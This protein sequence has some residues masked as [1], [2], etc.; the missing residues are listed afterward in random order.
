[1]KWW[2]AFGLALVA[3]SLAGNAGLAQDGSIAGVAA[4]QAQKRQHEVKAAQTMF[5]AG[6]QAFA[7]QS[8]GEAMDNFK[9]AF[10]AIP[11]V[12]AVADQR[13]VFFK[14]YQTASLEFAK[15]LIEDA[16]WVEAENTLSEVM[17]TAQRHTVPTTLIDPQVR[18]VLGDLKSKDDRYNMANSPR[19][20][21][22]I[23]VVES[24]LVLAKGYL[25]L[26]DFDRAERTYNE[27]LIVDP[28]STASRR[29]LEDVARHRM[30]YYDAAYDHTRSKML[31][32]VT[33]AWESPIPLVDL[34]MSVG[35]VD[36]ADVAYGGSALIDQKLKDIIIPRIEF[37]G[38]RLTDV[39]DYLAQKSQE[40]D[41][42]EP[43][44]T[45]RGVNLVIDSTG[46]LGGE[47]L[48]QRALTV[49]LTN[50]PLSDALKYVSQL[51]GM[52]YRVDQFAVFIVP[53][54]VEFDAGYITRR[55]SVPPGF[56]SS[57]EQG[58]GAA[59]GFSD[60]FA[61]PVAESGIRV[62]R[63][64]AKE[65]LEKSGVVFSPG[66]SASYAAATSTLIVT[67]TIDQLSTVEYLIE[68]AKASGD[69]MVQ[70]NVRMV[71][72][73]EEG[74]K[75]LGMDW[76]LGASSIGSSQS[77]FFAGGTDGNSSTP[78]AADDFPFLN[79]GGVPVG[80]N[81]ISGGL[82]MGDLSTTQ[83]IQ[84]VINRGS[85]GAGSTKYPGVFSVA[86][87]L[88]DP[89]FQVVVRAL[90]QHK[91]TDF[92]CNSHVLVKP[93]QIASLEQ[94]REFIYPSEY[95][96]PEIPNTVG[97]NNTSVIFDIFGNI[98]GIQQGGNLAAPITPAHPTAFETRKL[99][100][101]IEVEPSVSSDNLTVNL[102]VSTDFTDF[103]GYINYGVPITDHTIRDAFGN[104]AIQTPNEILMPVFDSVRETTNVTVW[105]GQTI[106]IGGF[107]GEGVTTGEDK[108]PVIGDLPGIGRAFR[109]SQQTSNKKA[110]VIF[111]SVLLV[112]PGGNPIN[113]KADSEVV[114]SQ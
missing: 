96:P 43:D 12:P 77:T 97:N 37:N 113:A 41:L 101:V 45:R 99:G 24:K 83:S 1:M 33:E 78:T 103:V 50:V 18:A 46:A 32:E 60:P 105:D 114:L 23:D 80:M 102:N 13:R 31:A 64:T 92:L 111:V 21:R 34:G 93:G 100:K 69:K 82:R 68:T 79:P 48:S 91:G 54:T 94:T 86:G 52:K 26:G 89:Q 95:D 7:D 59:A 19:H 11:N 85:P 66:A 88:T 107:H 35:P 36:E 63:I 58:A 110:L 28:Y 108:I 55:Y 70:V 20:I 109:S 16:H 17:E 72:I 81:P 90:S 73:E 106:A 61:E 56:V 74:L 15:Q 49:Q 29:G 14:R 98:I 65:F 9:A 84:D 71:S 67:N 6:S 53:S 3:L 42:G 51:V 38:A 75:A 25:E 22:N 40:L 57:G 39:V 104:A 27:I 76:L 30:N 87:L 47:D 5:T 8:Y 112:D 62:S 4:Q 44:P 10:E 2:R